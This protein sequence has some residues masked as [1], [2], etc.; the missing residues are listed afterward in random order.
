MPAGAVIECH[1]S[2]FIFGWLH[3]SVMGCASALPEYT[4]RHATASTEHD[5]T[6]GDIGI[7]T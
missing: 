5:K 6:R 3:M 7:L 1:F 4:S 2:V